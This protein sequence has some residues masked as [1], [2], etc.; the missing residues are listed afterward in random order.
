M[1]Y[2]N[3][4]E[5]REERQREETSKILSIGP[6]PP[7][8]LRSLRSVLSSHLDDYC[9]NDI[10]RGIPALLHSNRDQEDQEDQ[11]DRGD[12]EDQWTKC[13]L[14]W[15]PIVVPVEII[16]MPCYDM[17]F[18]SCNT[19]IRLCLYC[20]IHFFQLHRKSIDRE[21][22]KKC[23][24]CPQ[25]IRLHHLHLNNTFRVDFTMIRTMIDREERKKHRSLCWTCPFCGTEEIQAIHMTRHILADCP[26]YYEECECHDI[27][28]RGDKEIHRQRCTSYRK[29]AQCAEFVRKI[30]FAFHMRNMHQQIECQD[31]KVYVN[32][33]HLSIHRKT[34]CFFRS[35]MCEICSQSIVFS[36]MQNHLEN[37]VFALE[38][39]DRQ[40]KDQIQENQQM[41]DNYRRLV[42]KHRQ[43][44]NPTLTE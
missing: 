35:M 38:I 18:L 17:N 37:H 9:S 31:C 39:K 5:K 40:L 30:N 25:R 23:I 10:T 1:R 33:V 24:Y 42:Q 44:Y 21:Y 36:N 15:E 16:C 2:D 6:S 8:D 32:L 29:C 14:C 34:E 41:I 26:M 28:V 43:L 3:N 7:P 27:I 19:H 20:C 4:N 11:E 12:Q 13:I 22:A